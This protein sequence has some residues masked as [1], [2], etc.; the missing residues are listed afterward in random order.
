MT[1]DRA[2]SSPLPSEAVVVTSPH[3]GRSRELARARRTLDR[4][5]IDVAE[6]LEIEHLDRLPELLR[7][8]N[9]EPRLVIAA[10][11]TAP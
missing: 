4:H 5:R 7:T 10:A 1:H 11:A 8:A 3:A 6:E 9:G 2:G